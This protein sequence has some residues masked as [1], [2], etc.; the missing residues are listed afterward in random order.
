[1]KRTH[2][3]QRQV[4]VYVRVSTGGQEL[5]SQI[6]DLERWLAAYAAGAEVRWYHDKASGATSDRPGWRELEAALRAGEVARLVVWRLDRLGRM[7]AAL[8]TLLD[9]LVHLGVGFTSVREGI[10]L[11]TPA[12]RMLSGIL[13]SVAQYEREVARER[14]T[15]GIAAAKAAGKRWGGRRTGARWKVTPEIERQVLRMRA[16]GESVAATARLLNLSRGTVYAILRV[17]APLTERSA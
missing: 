9:D 2:T 8:T 1:M 3:A 6:P 12:G 15:A 10:D 17:A 13:A 16:G 11:E 7:A 5:R 4:A 14:Q